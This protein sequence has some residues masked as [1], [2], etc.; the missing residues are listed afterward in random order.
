MQPNV[1]FTDTRLGILLRFNEDEEF[2][3]GGKSIDIGRAIVLEIK[4]S[5]IVG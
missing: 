5:I 4:D 2:Y 1:S 3:D